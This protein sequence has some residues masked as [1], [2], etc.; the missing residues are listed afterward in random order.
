MVLYK[1]YFYYYY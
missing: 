1:F